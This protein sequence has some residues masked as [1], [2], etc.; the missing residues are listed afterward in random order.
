MASNLN[1]FDY[2][3]LPFQQN[4]YDSLAFSLDIN[5]SELTP[6]IYKTNSSE[7]GSRIFLGHQFNRYIAIES[8]VTPLGKKKFSVIPEETGDDINTEKNQ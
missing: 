7:K 1:S 8:G 4:N 3:G 5:A 2:F 6:S